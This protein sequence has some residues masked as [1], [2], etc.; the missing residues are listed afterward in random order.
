MLDMFQRYEPVEDKEGFANI[1]RIDISEWLK[2][3]DVI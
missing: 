2:Y 3:E 1:K